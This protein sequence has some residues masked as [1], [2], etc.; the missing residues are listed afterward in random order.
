MNISTGPFNIVNLTNVQDGTWAGYLIDGAGHNLTFSGVSGHYE[1]WNLGNGGGNISTIGAS[2]STVGLGNG[3]WN[4]TGIK[5]AM[6]GS[7]AT[8]SGPITAYVYSPFGLQYNIQLLG[9]WHIY[10]SVNVSHA[11]TTAGTVFD[12][13]CAT[14]HSI[15][16]WT[17]DLGNYRGCF[18]IDTFQYWYNGPNR[19]F[20]IKITTDGSTPK[21]GAVVKLYNATGSLEN[22]ATTGSDGLVNVSSKFANGYQAAPFD[23]AARNITVDDAYAG[24]VFFNSSTNGYVIYTVAAG[25]DTTKPLV[26]IQQPTNQWYSSAPP[27]KLHCNR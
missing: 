22:Q 20:P 7:A 1:G 12:F 14:N 17:A 27:L 15:T 5:T 19:T 25:G 13:D 10:N 24:Q 3:T 9:T 6:G 2:T 16:T 21:S 4:F 8:F 11:R 18:R 23:T 26:T